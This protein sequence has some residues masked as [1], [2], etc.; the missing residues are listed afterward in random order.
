[1]IYSGLLFCLSSCSSGADSEESELDDDF[2]IPSDNHST[3]SSKDSVKSTSF[4]AMFP[5]MHQVY[6]MQPEVPKQGDL[7]LLRRHVQS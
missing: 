1:M 6:G 3:P 5:S 4:E 2:G 7:Q